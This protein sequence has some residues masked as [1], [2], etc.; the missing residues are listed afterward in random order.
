MLW[1]IVWIFWWFVDKL[2]DLDLDF[3][4]FVW[5]KDLVFRGWYDLVF[6]LN[7]L[8]DLVVGALVWVVCFKFGF[9]VCV[10]I[11][12]CL[13]GMCFILVLIFF[14]CLRVDFV[15]FMCCLSIFGGLCWI[16]LFDLNLWTLTLV[17]FW[18][19]FDYVYCYLDV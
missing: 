17:L 3:S 14:G 19:W 16:A 1:L 2:V 12:F 5:M 6:G 9:A 11:L 8:I 4:L 7:W 15:G 13:F 10:L 18:D